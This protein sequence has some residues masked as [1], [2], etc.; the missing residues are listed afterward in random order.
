MSTNKKELARLLFGTEQK[1]S[2]K[3]AKF[4]KRDTKEES[5]TTF[6]GLTIEQI[7]LF[8]QKATNDSTRADL[9]L[10]LGNTYLEGRKNVPKD[11]K[12]AYKNFL[13]AANLGHQGAQYNVALLIEDVIFKNKNSKHKLPVQN[14]EKIYLEMLAKVISGPDKRLIAEAHYKMGIHHFDA[15]TDKT[16]EINASSLKSAFEHFMTST[17]IMPSAMSFYYIGI[18]KEEGYGTPKNLLQAFSA[19]CEAFARDT[20]NAEFAL[21]VGTFYEYGYGVMPISHKNALKFYEKAREL[22]SVRATWRLCVICLQNRS[23]EQTKQQGLLY[24]KSLKDVDDSEIQ[25]KMGQVFENGSLG[26]E[27]SPEKAFSCYMKASHDKSLPKASEKLAECYLRGFGVAKNI[28][29]AFEIFNNPDL[30]LKIDAGLRLELAENLYEAALLYMSGISVNGKSVTRNSSKVLEYLYKAVQEKSVAAQNLL[31]LCLIRPSAFGLIGIKS[32]QKRGIQL[33]KEI[34]KES[35]ESHDAENN[36]GSCDL[37]GIAENPNILYQIGC[38]H[39]DGNSNISDPERAFEFFSKA[40]ELGHKNAKFEVGRAYAEGLGVAV[41]TDLAFKI[42]AENSKENV[43]SLLYLARM[44]LK[45]QGHYAK[46]D[47]VKMFRFAMAHGWEDAIA[48]LGYCYEMGLGGLRQNSSEAQRLYK[49]A[50]SKESA[51]ACYYGGR[52]LERKNDPKFM[53]EAIQL[54]SDGALAGNAWCLNRMGS[55]Y[56]KGYLPLV[57]QNPEK[58]FSNFY[59]AAK[60]H[61]PEAQYNLARCYEKGIGTSVDLTQALYWYEKSSRGDCRDATFAYQRLQRSSSPPEIVRFTSKDMTQDKT[62]KQNGINGIRK[63]Y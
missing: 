3:K 25:F 31:A 43:D 48:H 59:L 18:C 44:T 34:E 27:I 32:D 63:F 19:Y 55:F 28:D 21:K 51:L 58:A 56:E 46:S 39:L 12:E 26:I 13:F 45:G 23:I 22:G 10:F 5:L 62:R 7:K 16:I 15:V 30:K 37:N 40:A 52:C 6:E 35:K 11:L 9:L 29:K 53:Q 54:Y 24:L 36:L 20:H 41:N 33:L 61:H 50:I 49:Q 14:P 57:E 17:E 60:Y 2:V 1:Q 42:H 47:A 4:G 8:I 38:F